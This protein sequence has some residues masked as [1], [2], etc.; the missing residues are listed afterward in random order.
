V[1]QANEDLLQAGGNAHQ[2][3]Q[4]MQQEH[5]ATERAASAAAPVGRSLAGAQGMVGKVRQWLSL[6]DKRRWLDEAQRAVRESAARLAAER[7]QIAAD[8]DT[9][10]AA[11]GRPA[12]GT[13]VPPPA[14]ASRPTAQ[15]ADAAQSL[16]SLTRQLAAEQHRL[17]LR[18]ERIRARE[19]LARI[20][21]Q[22]DAV[23][24][25]QVR[26]ILHA[27]LA[28]TAIVLGALLL[29]LFA[30]SWLE[31]LLAR[32][33]IDRRQLQTLRSVIGVALQIV[34]VVV[35][36]LVLVGV[37]GQLG[38]MLGLA[39]AGL[40]VALKDFIVAFIGWFVLMGRNGVHLG[41]WVEINGVSGE[42][43]ELGMFH[44]VL[45]ETGNWTDAGHPTG[46]HVTFT[47]SFAI[48][49]H[50]FNFSTTGQWL[51]DEI[52]VVVPYGRDSHAIAT[53]IEKEA[54]AA[55][56]NSAGEAEEEWRRASRGQRG[57]SVSAQPGVAVRPAGGGVEIVVRYVTRA[58]ERLAVRARLY[59]AAV[60]L[61][62]QGGTAGG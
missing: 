29:L 53:A 51:W 31:H 17:T 45:L 4:M 25:A 57:A 12:A 58:A 42:V 26:N 38:T 56:A 21:L 41:D 8:L 34:G 2:R 61:L 43:I 44:T 13:P 24:A 6:R 18:D 3:I 27:C 37:P 55:T 30:D 15:G 46:R 35:I 7:T 59:Q 23:V 60:Q 47:N 10:K 52:S 14:Q 32:A 33:P 50:Y 20:Y 62:A 11:L 28:G 1:Q 40:T 54:V 22:W 5:A 19:R 39:G 16:L 48:E 9:S 36:L 49:G